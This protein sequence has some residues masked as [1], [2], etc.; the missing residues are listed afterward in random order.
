[1]TNPALLDRQ[2]VLLDTAFGSVKTVT[3]VGDN[4]SHFVNLSA[5]IS[6]I[7]VG[8]IAHGGECAFASEWSNFSKEAFVKKCRN[9]HQ[10]VSDIVPFPAE[11]VPDNAHCLQAAPN[12]SRGRG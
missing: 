9:L 4:G 1:M 5:G 8:F 10:F 6:A 11:Y 12:I 3:Q 2:I 7:C